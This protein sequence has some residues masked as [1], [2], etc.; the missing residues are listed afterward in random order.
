MICNIP[1][2]VERP[3]PKST[4]VPAVIVTFVSNTKVPPLTAVN[5]LFAALLE[6]L[7]VLPVVPVKVTTPPS[8]LTL[9]EVVLFRFKV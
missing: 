8:A 1:L 7:I 2:T 3:A 4:P 6:T 9:D 5:D